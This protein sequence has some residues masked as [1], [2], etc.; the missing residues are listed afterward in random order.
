MYGFRISRA[1]TARTFEGRPTPCMP[2]G[3][4]PVVLQSCVDRKE[5]RLIECDPATLDCYGKDS[6]NPDFFRRMRADSGAGDWMLICD[7]KKAP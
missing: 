6:F 2:G 4:K 7:P 1:P 3:A 5:R